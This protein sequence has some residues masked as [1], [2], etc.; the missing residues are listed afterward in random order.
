MITRRSED[1]WK[2]KGPLLKVIWWADDST[3]PVNR[4]CQTRVTL[5]VCFKTFHL[6]RFP[7]FNPF[8]AF[9]ADSRFLSTDDQ[10]R[11]LTRSIR[12]EVAKLTEQWNHLINRSDNWKHRLDEYMTVCRFER[13]ISNQRNFDWNFGAHQKPALDFLKFLRFHWQREWNT[14]LLKATAPEVM[15]GC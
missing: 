10:N 12:R 13:K 4:R 14:V 2:T 3:L 11:E 7:N 1:N 9:D 15:N 5:K 6:I 8:T